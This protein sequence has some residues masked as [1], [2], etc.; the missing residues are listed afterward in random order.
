VVQ[1]KPIQYLSF[2]VLESFDAHGKEA[3]DQGKLFKAVH[4]L[5]L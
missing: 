5:F 3:Y 2:K 1:A 4:E